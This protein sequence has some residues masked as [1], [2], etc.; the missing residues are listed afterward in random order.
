MPAADCVL[1]H[2][3]LE[4][5]ADWDSDAAGLAALARRA[6]LAEG[7]VPAEPAAGQLLSQALPKM[8][9]LA[10]QDCKGVWPSPP[11]DSLTEV[12]GIRT[13]P[14]RTRVQDV[15]DGRWIR[16]NVC[17]AHS[18]NHSSCHFSTAN[19]FRFQRATVK[20]RLGKGTLRP[21][22][23]TRMTTRRR[24]NGG[25][26][27]CD[28][29]VDTTSFATVLAGIITACHLSAS[30]NRPNESIPT[31]IHRHQACWAPGRTHHNCRLPPA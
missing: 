22:R 4:P 3:G 13:Q 18:A 31:V 20:A 17:I 2:P 6:L 28:E 21:W 26:W 16:C 23:W 29:I 10:S 7:L 24:Q 8:S 19:C 27:R 14:G 15:Q 1:E 5:D 30:R 12:A 9:H 11:L 25:S